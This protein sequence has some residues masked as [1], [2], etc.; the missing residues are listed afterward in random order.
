MS[1]IGRKLIDIPAGVKVQISG[2][3]V[4]VQGPKGKMHVKLPTRHQV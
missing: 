2:A 1:R 3:G 4:D